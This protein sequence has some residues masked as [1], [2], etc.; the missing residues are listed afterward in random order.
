[1]FTSKP[2]SSLTRGIIDTFPAIADDTFF[3]TQK[4]IKLGFDPTSNFLHLG[5]S[6]LLR[7]LR[8][9]QDQGH[10]PVVIIG[11][12][13][14]RIG[15]PTGKSSVRKQLSKEEVDSNIDSFITAISRFVNLE[16][17]ELVLNSSHLECLH[18][19]D[20]VK[21]QSIT[22]VQQMIA[23]QDFAHRIELQTPIRLHEFMYPLLQ[24]YDSFHVESDVELGGTDQKF[25]VGL[26][27][28]VQKHFDSPVQ[29]VGMLMPILPGTDGVQKMSKSLNNA[30]GLDEHPLQMFSKLEKVPDQLVNDYITLLTD[31]NLDQFPENP[32]ERQKR[33]AV[34]V[35]STFHGREKALK[36]LK[37]SEALVFSQTIEVNVP[38]VST[39]GVDFP[40][41]LA[42]IL[43]TLNL[44]ESTSE[45]RRKIKAGS[46]KVD[47]VG[48]TDENLTIESVSKGVI[49]QL[50]KKDFFKLV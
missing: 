9:F 24:G 10:I 31:C 47:G 34:E 48:V 44:V 16:K 49:V 13:T 27:R 45:A 39:K 2:P 46:V 1:M 19:S 33:M 8:T 17:C 20:I 23:K 29:Q 35:V 43:K 15:D 12:F 7:K 5:H 37:D 38:E 4:R 18:L 28:E 42:T 41:R 36:A 32:R 30:I 6:V 22:T 40:C 11:D 25:N 26:G 50:S 14:A 3:T 21:L